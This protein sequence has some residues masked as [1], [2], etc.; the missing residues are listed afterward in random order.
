MTEA[1]SAQ[2]TNAPPT[3][4]AT[5]SSSSSGTTPRTSYALKMERRSRRGTVP[6]SYSRRSSR[7]GLRSAT[8]PLEPRST[9]L[10]ALRD[11]TADDRAERNRLTVAVPPLRL[12]QVAGREGKVAAADAHRDRDDVALVADRTRPLELVELVGLVGHVHIWSASHPG[13]DNDPHSSFRLVRPKV[14]A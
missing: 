12:A 9:R 10:T 6:A 5:S 14:L 1:R 2:S 3:R 13:G 7:I 11:H 4:R 8:A